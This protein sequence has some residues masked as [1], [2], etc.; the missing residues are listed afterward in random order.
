MHWTILW[1]Q[2]QVNLWSER[3]RRE[4]GNLPP[5]HKSYS[6][7]QLK[8]WNMFQIK[9]TERFLLYLPS[10]LKYK[11]QQRIQLFFWSCHSLCQQRIW[12]LFLS[13]VSKHLNIEFIYFL[14]C[15]SCH[16]S[17]G[18]TCFLSYIVYFTLPHRFQ[19]DSTYS[20]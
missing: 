8:L 17:K 7:K 19:V 4:D 1:F 2:N 15:G 9:A 6:I 18:C 10:L 3:S 12:L 20:T 14:G 5:G 13:Y 16:F 11:Y